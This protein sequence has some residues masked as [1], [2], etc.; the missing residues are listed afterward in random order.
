MAQFWPLH[1][2]YSPT[3]TEG[4]A[5][6]V[7]ELVRYLNYATGQGAATAL[8]YAATAQHLAGGLAAAAGGLDQT[9]D[10]LISR[11]QRWIQDPSLYDDVAGRG[12]HAAAEH[13]AEA[14]T[15]ALSEAAGAAAALAG[16]LTRAH[17][18]L[19][20]LGHDE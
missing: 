13:R 8:P 17:S 11:V 3:R 1:G 2:P 18:E 19:S 5:H 20:H 9:L 12:D 14:A 6:T 16:A 4:A 7:D 15:A 10:Q